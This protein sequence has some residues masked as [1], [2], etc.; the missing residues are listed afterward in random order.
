[1]ATRLITINLRR[2]LV[3]QPRNK[4]MYKAARYVRERVAHYTKTPEENVKM[5]QALSAIIAK[6]YS[7]SLKLLKLSVDIKDNIARVTAYS[8]KAD[9]KAPAEKGKA[10]VQPAAK[11]KETKAPEAKRQ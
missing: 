3:R 9:V 2:Y 4:R 6:K 1:M 11:Q 7:R 5:D 8:E 10:V